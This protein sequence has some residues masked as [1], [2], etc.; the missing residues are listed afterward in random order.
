MQLECFFNYFKGKLI[1]YF[2]DVLIACMISYLK[3]Y[4]FLNLLA[5][6]NNEGTDEEDWIHTATKQSHIYPCQHHIF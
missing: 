5:G 4:F 6:L 2:S 3:S 1:I